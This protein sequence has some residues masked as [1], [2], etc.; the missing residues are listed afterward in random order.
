M[1]HEE[2]SHEPKHEHKH[3][4][5]NDHH[6]AGPVPS[7]TGQPPAAAAKEETPPLTTQAKVYEAL[8]AENEDLRQ[9]VLR[10]QADFQNF[11]RRS[12]REILETRQRAEADFARDLLVVLDHMDAALASSSD[13]A[14]L[15]NGVK[16]TNDEFK[17]LLANRGIESFDA[18]GQPFDPHQH[19]AVMHEPSD[20]H[21]PMTVTQTFQSGYKSGDK[22]LRP[23]KVKV[24][25]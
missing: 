8:K 23:A 13:Y 22:V 6:P 12:A 14:T 4:P 21:P 20:A 19:E 1:A 9:K 11:Q 18:T 17:K 16:I 3:V 24:S 25:K 7:G 2:K 5:G 10:W 15:L